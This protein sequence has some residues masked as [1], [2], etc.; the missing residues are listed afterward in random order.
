MAKFFFMRVYGQRGRRETRSI[1][2]HLDP[3]GL[4]KKEIIIICMENT[5]FFQ[6]FPFF[7]TLSDCSK[8]FK[9]IPS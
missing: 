2:S 3:T 9:K 6:K 1:S 4:V 5:I 8:N 7:F